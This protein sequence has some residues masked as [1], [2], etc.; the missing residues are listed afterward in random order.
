MYSRLHVRPTA[1]HSDQIITAFLLT[2]FCHLPVITTFDSRSAL[3]FDAHK[4]T[5]AQVQ[6]VQLLEKRAAMKNRF[7]ATLQEY[8][9]RDD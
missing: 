7:S 1:K 6:R 4:T 5:S 8:R 2:L 3:P 9:R